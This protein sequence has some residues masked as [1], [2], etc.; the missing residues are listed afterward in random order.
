MNESMM[1]FTFTCKRLMWWRVNI[2][3]SFVMWFV[4]NTCCSSTSVC[5]YSRS[6]L[7][8]RVVS[9][10]VSCISTA[11]SRTHR[12]PACLLWILSPFSSSVSVG[13]RP[14]PCR[15]EH[16]PSLTRASLLSPDAVRAKWG[17][18]HVQPF[19]ILDQRAATGA[20]RT[21]AACWRSPPAICS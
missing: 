4:V 14:C 19:I 20:E 3:D 8:Y 15:A 7:G 17:F 11:S 6:L 10:H 16:T 13:V 5:D 9:W 18:G 2:Y 1:M 21:L 12:L